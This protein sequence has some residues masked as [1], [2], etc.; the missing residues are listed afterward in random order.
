MGQGLSSGLYRYSLIFSPTTTLRGGCWDDAYF[1]D[2]E[3]EAKSCTLCAVGTALEPGTEQWTGR[4]WSLPWGNS[5]GEANNKQKR[6]LVVKCKQ[7]NK[8]LCW[9]ARGGAPSKDVL[10]EL[11]PKGEEEGGSPGRRPAACPRGAFCLERPSLCFSALTPRSLSSAWLGS[12][13]LYGWEAHW[14]VGGGLL[15]PTEALVL[16]SCPLHCLLFPPCSR[17]RP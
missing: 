14:G 3:T 15:G 8:P 1:T 13:L 17:G 10:F 7:E 16:P 5:A 6:K 2:E 12:Q 11:R 4:T 9:R